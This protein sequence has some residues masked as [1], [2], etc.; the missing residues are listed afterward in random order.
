MSKNMRI[1]F[2]FLWPSHNI[3]TLLSLRFML[4]NCGTYFFEEMTKVNK[5]SE[6]KPP[7]KMYKKV[8]GPTVTYAF[9]AKKFLILKLIGSNML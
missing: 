4:K 6:I 5:L 3:L 2:K 8:H 1:V 9:S 7:L